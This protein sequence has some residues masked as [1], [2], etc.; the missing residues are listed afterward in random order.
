[1]LALM[2]RL[3][4]TGYLTGLTVSV[5]FHWLG[6][7]R[8]QRRETEPPPLEG[9]EELPSPLLLF[10][11]LRD[12]R[13]PTACASETVLASKR[14]TSQADTG[15]ILPPSRARALPLPI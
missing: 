9:D 8:R 11:F 12:S 1:M 14:L 15:A 4:G 2:V 5:C 13:Q 6:G 7:H 10:S 3:K